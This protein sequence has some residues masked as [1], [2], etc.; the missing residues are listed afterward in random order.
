MSSTWSRTSRAFHWAGA[1]FIFYLLIHG[2]WM[3]GLPREL[4]FGH[5][6]T[7]AA[8]GYLF[9]AFTLA[10][11]V[12]RWTHDV[13]PLPARAPRWER[14]A[15]HAGHWGLYLLMLGSCTT[16]SRL[17]TSGCRGRSP[18][19]CSPISPR[20]SITGCGARTT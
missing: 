13:P 12:W 1:A 2:F 18:C 8:V 3:T 10:R 19:L 9:I 6:E 20:P 16:R 4:R 14:A 11:L 15:G 7:H 5:Y 17:R